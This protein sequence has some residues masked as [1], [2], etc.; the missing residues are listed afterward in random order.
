MNS[1]KFKRMKVHTLLYFNP[2]KRN[3][4]I[5]KRL[6]LAPALFF[7]VNCSSDS[8]G[9]G[10]GLTQP[11]VDATF[12]V[13]KTAENKYHL[14]RAYNNYILSKWNIDNN[15]Y[16]TGKSE[17]DI[18]FLDAGSYVIQHQ[19]IG[20]GGEVGGTSSQ[21]IVVPTSDP[22]SGNIIQGGRFDT[23]EE[24]SKWSKHIIS[25]TQAEWVFANGAVTMVANEGRQQGIYQAINVEAGQKYAIDMVTSSETALVDTWFEVYVL[26]SIPASGTDVSGTVYRNI[27]TWDGCGKGQFKGKV[28]SIGCNP[29][30][31]GGVYT[32]TTTG[33][34]Y[35]F[36]KCGGKTVNGLSID[37]VEFRKI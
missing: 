31:N 17:E 28:S 29:S 15:G 12:T 2:G 8:I 7:L 30:K 24:I 37:K 20:I 6:L 14:K 35:L 13:T 1:R 34:V 33:K 9:D 22:V 23:P 21:T 11:S 16:N 4:Y 36:I 19:A 32:A 25:S 18:S 26:N 10:N 27:N 5:G 3:K